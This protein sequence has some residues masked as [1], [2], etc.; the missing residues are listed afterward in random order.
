MRRRL[1]EGW[2]HYRGSLGGVWEVWRQDK[3]SNHFNV[4]WEAVTVPHCF[5]AFDTVD[6]DVQYYQGQ[7]WYRMKL[8]LDNPYPRGRTLLHFEGAAQR[9]EIYVYTEKAGGHLGGYDEFTVDITEAAR[10][11]LAVGRYQ[12]WTPV[13]VL[14]DNTRDL[15][16]IPSDISD[17]N[18]YGGLHR[19]VNL[20][21]VPAVSLERVLVDVSDVSGETAKVRIRARLYNPDRFA[22]NVELQISLTAPD[23]TVVA[24]TRVTGSPWEGER[25]LAAFRL[26]SPALWSTENPR[27]YRCTVKLATV[28]GKHEVTE[29]FGVRSFEFVRKG[30][31]KLNGK[32]LLLRGTHRHED[33]AGVGSAL[34]EEMMVREMRMIKEMGA[35]FIRLGHYQQSRIILDLCDELGILVWEEIPWC[36]G[37]LGGESYKQQCRDMLTAMIDQHYNH[38]SV[39]LWGLGNENDWEADFD[40]FDKEAIRSFMKELHELSHRL[41]PSRLTAIRRCEFCKD[42][43]DVYSPSIWAGWYRGIYTEYEKYTREGF[44][45]VDRFLHVEWGADNVAGRHM[46]EPYTGFRVIRTGQGADERDGDYLMTGGA[47]RVSVLGDWSETYFCEMADW[48]LKCQENMDWLTGAAQWPFKD[49]STPVR[50]DSPVPYMNLKGIVERD[51]TKKE[52]FYVFQSYWSEEPMVRLYAHSQKYRW[53]KPGERKLIKVYSNCE[54]AELF[55]NGRSQGGKRRN[56]QDFPCAG[57]RWEVELQ[58]GENRLRVEARKGDAAVADETSFV[59]LT[60]AWEEPAQVRLSVDP[61]KDGRV[62]LQAEVFDRHGVPCPDAARFVRF[63]LAGDGRLIDNLGTV[64]GS[65]LVQLTNGRAGIYIDPQGGVSVASVSVEGLPTVFREIR[66]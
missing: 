57:L 36:R 38:P 40:Y 56:S 55:V 64:H 39:V 33:Y 30:P 21:Y 65:R 27:L 42:L 20:V 47:P 5:N 26:E 14:C 66:A 2:E 37:G 61:Q 7:G 34:T 53:G 12:G 6:P 10:R 52:A 45:S 3:L 62:F 32:R 17:F 54:E 18:L 19:Y 23:G 44:E 29:R 13:A 25:E 51:L 11:A 22:E 31:F 63:G 4:S 49:F 9:A 35:N 50:P 59:Y 8:K 43:V 1:T 48:Y 24:E 41:D 60:Q 16:T 58:P 15:E 46:E 28:H